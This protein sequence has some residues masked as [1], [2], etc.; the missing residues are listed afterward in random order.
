MPDKK[1]SRERLQLQ[2]EKL[3]LPI[4]KQEILFYFTKDDAKIVNLMMSKVSRNGNSS[5]VEVA[6]KIIE[7]DERVSRGETRRLHYERDQNP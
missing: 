4:K 3:K 7:D 5:V 1:F 6:E 2:R